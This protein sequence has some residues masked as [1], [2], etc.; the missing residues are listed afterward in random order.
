MSLNQYVSE[1]LKIGMLPVSHIFPGSRLLFNSIIFL[2][3]TKKLPEFS[4][5]MGKVYPGQLKPRYQIPEP[6]NQLMKK[7]CDDGCL[8]KPLRIFVKPKEFEES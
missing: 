3:A 1:H 4:G 8:L 2:E 7:S 5:L 6:R